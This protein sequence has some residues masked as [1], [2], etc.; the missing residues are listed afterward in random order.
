[1]GY[2]RYLLLFVVF[3]VSCFTVIDQAVHAEEE[4][5][6]RTEA[7]LESF[8]KIS[9]QSKNF[10][11]VGLVEEGQL[12]FYL[13]HFNGNYPVKDA[14]V[15]VTYKG[16][17]FSTKLVGIGVY[18]TQEANFSVPH[19]YDLSF[20]IKTPQLSE[21]IHGILRVLAPQEKQKEKLVPEQPWGNTAIS[22]LIISLVALALLSKFT[23]AKMPLRKRKKTDSAGKVALLVP[24]FLLMG[25][26]SGQLLAHTEHDHLADVPGY[27]ETAEDRAKKFPDGSVY[28]PKMAQ[29]LIGIRTQLVKPEVVKIGIRLTGHVQANPNFAGKVQAAQ[30]GRVDVM[31]GQLPHIGQW[32]EKND[33]LLQISSISPRFEQGNQQA[34]LAGLEN[35]LQLAKNKL[36]RL[37]KLSG[38]I[39]QKT[40]DEARTEVKSLQ[41][42]FKAVSTSLVT[43]ESLR[44]PISGFIT[45]SNVLP[46]QIVEAR[47]TLFEIMNPQ[48]LQVE[49]LAYGDFHSIVSEQA[50]VVVEGME[51][52]PLISLGTGSVLRGHALPLLF[53]VAIENPKLSVG[54]VVNVIITTGEK[55]RGR[56]VQRD[57]IVK[58]EQGKYMVWLHTDPEIFVPEIVEWE[59]V[60]N[61]SVVITTPLP[62]GV[63]IVDHHASRLLQ[64]R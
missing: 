5:A 12:W 39:P 14:V 61:E 33:L 23:K 28:L 24:A 9:L 7:P 3:F 17:E 46:G 2:I 37:E 19:S 48:K 11:I 8:P 34:E 35:S 56:V 27:S 26:H 36:R 30:A 53:D 52:I 43:K 54:Q 22:L 15:T 60:D 44:A 47:E 49:A 59:T 55:I 50:E 41:G 57:S 58:N 29:H 13:D 38:T 45:A 6:V 32:V 64:I 31:G 10:E 4:N 42:K 25:F 18:L 40:I 63:R 1:M 20:S 51:P 62:R 16:K 21:T